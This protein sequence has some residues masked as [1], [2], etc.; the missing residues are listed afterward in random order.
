MPVS[1]PRCRRAIRWAS[2]MSRLALPFAVTTSDISAR[3]SRTVG[4]ERLD[5]RDEKLKLDNLN[6]MS[7]TTEMIHAEQM[8]DLGGAITWVESAPGRYRVTNQSEMIFRAC[9]VIRRSGDDIEYATLG[10]LMPEG[11]Y[12][13]SPRSAQE[14]QEL[15]AA[16]RSQLDGDVAVRF[17]V[18]LFPL[19]EM[20]TNPDRLNDGD[21]VLVGVSD[22]ELGGM[23]NPPGASQRTFRS[24][25]VA[26]LAY[27]NYP[28][29]QADF[30]S[31]V[32]FRKR[33]EEA[34]DRT[35]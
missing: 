34:D 26:N 9:F 31:A 3:S 30:N 16:W 7:T 22:E 1:I 12:T 5:K 6:V 18:K 24:V 17:E 32:E 21:V 20:A 19:I 10:T 4:L 25:L 33:M 8:L 23:Q 15:F 35:D 2:G 27:G 13:V 11:S 14:P 28:P 29:P